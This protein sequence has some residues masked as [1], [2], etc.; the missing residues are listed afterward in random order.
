MTEKGINSIVENMSLILPI[1]GKIMLRGVKAKTNYPPHVI[2]VM[3]ALNHHGKL[4]MT[5]IG[6]HLQL[7]KPQI[8]TLIDKLVADDLVE[9]SNDENDR[10]VIYIQL[11]TLGKEK[12]SEIKDLMSESLR[13][14]LTELEHDSLIQ[15][16]ESSSVVAKVLLQIS[17]KQQAKYCGCSASKTNE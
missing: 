3:A 13:A 6:I 15:L 14:A 8:T 7:P 17:L 11:T 9:R 4:T 12:F 16:Q 1:L 2:G 5:G 10:R